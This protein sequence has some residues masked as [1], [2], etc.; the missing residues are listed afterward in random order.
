MQ[1]LVYVANRSVCRT[2]GR[3]DLSVKLLTQPTEDLASLRR[4][5]ARRRVSAARIGLTAAG[6]I[7]LLKRVPRDHPVYVSPSDLAALVEAGDEQ[8]GG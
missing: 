8:R 1:E 3:D 6:Y 7:A 5:L 2:L 4:L